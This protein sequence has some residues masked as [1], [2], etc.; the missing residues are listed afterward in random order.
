M[1]RQA[2]IDE[3]AAP[4]V[5][6]NVSARKRTWNA[7]EV[8]RPLEIGNGSESRAASIASSSSTEKLGLRWRWRWR[9]RWSW[10]WSWH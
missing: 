10:S 5:R 6:C 1:L 8:R 3:S 9:W 2:P 7:C 4:V